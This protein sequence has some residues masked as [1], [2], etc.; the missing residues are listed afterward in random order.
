MNVIE[1]SKEQ[2]FNLL[3]NDNFINI[4]GTGILI[5]VNDSLYKVHYKTFFDTYIQKDIDYLDEEADMIL[6]N[7]KT[8]LAEEWSK[9][10][11]RLE[12]TFSAGTIKNVLTYRGIFVGI[13]MI[14]LRDYITL[15]KA[16]SK[17]KED[18]LKQ[19]M[20]NIWHLINNLLENDI[21]PTD[22]KEENIMVNID[23]LDVKLIDLDGIETRYGY[24]GYLN[25]YP[26][27][28]HRIIDSFS[29]M[30]RRI[31]KV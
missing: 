27:I 8:Y 20:G 3:V 17:L 15:T 25:E 16:S 22:I 13:E 2:L 21:A 10:F 26:Y 11:D 7:S 12:K 18:K 24:T 29:Q 28:K 4:G 23:S 31:K 1:L 9:K 14:Y 6:R 30:C 5:L 19:I